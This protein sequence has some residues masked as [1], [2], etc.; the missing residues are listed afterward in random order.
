MVGKIV[1]GRVAE[2]TNFSFFGSGIVRAHI[3]QSGKLS[4]SDITLIKA[5][6]SLSDN[7]RISWIE[8]PSLPGAEKIFVSAMAS[9][10]ACNS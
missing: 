5:V 8:I 9:F 4:R 2:G 7:I 1:I 10:Q 6:R 3:I